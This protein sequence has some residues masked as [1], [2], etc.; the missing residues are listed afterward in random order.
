MSGT[1]LSICIPTCNRAPFLRA[2]LQALA[3]SMPQG[4]AWE[5][6]IS[7][8]R[9]TDDT[10]SVVEQMRP[11]LPQLR[12]FLQR[13]SLPRIDNFIAALRLAESEWCLALA[14]DDALD[15]VALRKLVDRVTGRTD[16]A[17]CY[18]D[19][20]VH[21]AQGAMIKRYWRDWQG[22]REF[23]LGSALDLLVLFLDR[24]IVPEVALFHREAIQHALLG[25]GQAYAHLIWMFRLLTQGKVLLV[26]DRFY[27]EVEATPPLVRA[28]EGQRLTDRNSMRT[29]QPAI[30]FAALT[31]FR[32]ANA[33][34]LSIE[35]IVALI[36]ASEAYLLAGKVELRALAL[37]RE[38][39]QRA[40]ELD[41]SAHLVAPNFGN[42][43]ADPAFGMDHQDLITRC[44]LNNLA[45]AARLTPGCKG[46]VWVD[47]DASFAEHLAAVARHY[48]GLAFHHVGSTDK[49]APPDPACLVICRTQAVYDRLVAEASIVEDR[50]LSYEAVRHAVALTPGRV[51]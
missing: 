18:A 19:W 34:P 38:E 17:A 33:H 10:A 48:P 6:V 13:S 40:L 49:V 21:D 20:E 24:K 45:C 11:Q 7:D 30:D 2:T 28:R 47:F 14:D 39:W 50:L 25:V 32:A 12:Y 37:A 46:L 8:N 27:A 41:Q 43:A 36:S 4:V 15:L 1:Q 29:A 42:A 35:R 23:S 22:E 51:A 16:L 44:A 9:S 26:A 5:I 31:A 3:Q